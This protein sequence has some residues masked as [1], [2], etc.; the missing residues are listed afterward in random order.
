MRY[1]NLRKLTLAVALGLVALFATSELTYAQDWQIREQIRQQRQMER[2]QRQRERQQREYER[3]RQQQQQQYYGDQQQQGY[4]NNQQGN[5]NTRRYRVYTNGRYYNTDQRGAQL[6][7]QAV[8]NGYQQGFRAGQYDASRRNG[9]GYNSQNMYR[10]GNYGYQSY[11]DQSQYRYYFQQGFQKGYQDGYY[12][13]NQYGNNGTNILSSILST[14]LN[15]QQ[16]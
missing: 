16:Y 7:Q 2:E 15:I 1:F 14:I 10:S 9:Y 5:Y 4:Y 3:Q 11:V 8:N 6:L 13:R 12:R